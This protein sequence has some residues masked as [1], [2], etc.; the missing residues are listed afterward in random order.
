V[1]LLAGLIVV[2]VYVIP[3]LFEPQIVDATGMFSLVLLGIAFNGFAF[4]LN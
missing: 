4:W 2:I 3:R 1:V